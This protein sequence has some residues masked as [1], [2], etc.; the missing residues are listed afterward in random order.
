MASPLA[1]LV[2]SGD[3]TA[4]SESDELRAE[5][6][7]ESPS[8]SEDVVDAPR[9]GIEEITVTARQREESLQQTPISITAFSEQALAE[10]GI[11]DLSELT[12]YTPN[13]RFTAGAAQATSAQVYIR[14]IGQSEGTINAEPRVGIYVDG[15]YQARPLGSILSVF[16]LQRVEVLRGPQGTLYGKNAIGGAINVISNQPGPE[17][18]A[19]I[20]LEYGNYDYIA[21]RLM[22]NMP[23][24]LFGLGDKLF[25]RGN[26]VYENR[27]GYTYD[28]NL[29]ED[30]SSRNLIGGTA[31]VRFLP[32][33]GLD[34]RI[35]YHQTSED[36]K[37]NRGDCVLVEGM[38]DSGF[39]R[40]ALSPEGSQALGGDFVDACNASHELVISTNLPNRDVLDAKKIHGFITW[41]MPEL[42]LLGALTFES[43]T[44]YQSL[45]QD[46]NFDWDSTASTL[47]HSEIR[48]LGHAQ[49]SQEVR[50][51]G[52]A[53]DDR[54]QWTVGGFYLKEH[55][56]GPP[57]FT[58]IIAPDFKI[59]DTY[60]PLGIDITEESNFDHR[61]GAAFLFGTIEPIDRL[62]LTGGFRYGWEEKSLYKKREIDLCNYFSPPAV[63]E[64]ECFAQSV[65]PDGLYNVF[66]KITVPSS[67]E[68]SV[69]N[70]WTAPTGNISVTYDVMEEFHAYVGYQ[71]GFS[72]GGFNYIGDDVDQTPNAF[73]PETLDG[74]EVGV[75]S[76]W[77][78][79]RLTV[80]A[81][82]FWNYY[83]NM[84]V[85]VQEAQTSGTSDQFLSVQSQIRNAGQATL[86]G[87]EL[88]IVSMPIEGL[89]FNAGLG[90]TFPQYQDFMVLDVEATREASEIAS[91][92]S[93]GC[94]NGD[95][96][97]TIVPKQAD[98]TDNAFPNT[99]KVNFQLGLRYTWEFREGMELVPAVDYSWQQKVY[100]DIANTEELSQDDFG[101]LNASLA[102]Q[103]V[104]TDTR[105]VFWI[106]NATDELHSTG[107][108]SLGSWVSR[109]YGL[110]RTFGFTFT[111]RFGGP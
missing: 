31:S 47:I 108:F 11:R 105:I 33:D 106:K 71:R 27:F 35:N 78:D 63:P 56:W 42:P 30:F 6:D 88:E 18:D 44:G 59:Q 17:Y 73:E 32:V 99:P 75:K 67:T 48:D 62:H 102:V 111:Q 72:S 29:N 87:A 3:D 77:F 52:S 2:A 98:Y 49:L 65:G 46:F 19:K 107:G 83:D 37:S 104:Q 28:E 95:N 34:L 7:I 92:G 5:F 43:L 36:Q 10:R 81:N 110:P 61:T 79:R 109:Y 12:Q 70:S 50:F 60:F 84:Q 24:D 20:E 16:D 90:L 22:G 58:Q 69:T 4:A 91:C 53:W 68:A 76:S 15:I 51:H 57:T 21:T 39:M 14:G 74:V 100:F 103:L 25:L 80:N 54:V 8:E 86:Q 96:P 38:E 85:R 93:P 94:D 66:D 45:L 9:P 82:Y 41:D 89:L 40:A 97:L 13:L 101:L 1:A 26:F 55:T 64:T 23:V